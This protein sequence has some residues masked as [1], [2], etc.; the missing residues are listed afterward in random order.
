MQMAK[1]FLALGSFVFLSC[2]N[3]N[4]A[5]CKIPA[6]ARGFS[7]SPLGFPVT[8]ERTPEF[9]DDMEEFGDAAVRWNGSWRD[10]SIDGSDAGMIP[11]QAKLIQE[12]SYQYCYVATPVFEWRN[13][14][15]N[16]IQIP[17]NLVNDW[18]NVE[19]RKKFID[20]LREFVV[21]Y[22]PVYVFLGNENDLYYET[23]TADYAHWLIAYNTAY[24]AI[25]EANPDTLVGPV[26]SYEHI[27]GQGNLHGWSAPFWQAYDD[28]DPGK[29]DVV[30]ITLFPFFEYAKPES[31][32]SNYL[33]PLFDRI[34]TKPLVITATGWPAEN[35]DGFN[36]PW[37]PRLESQV[38][39]V[40]RL[41]IITAGENVPVMNWLYY[42]G[43]VD[44]GSDREFWKI[45]GS[46]SLLDSLGLPYL[47]YDDWLKL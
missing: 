36:P 15:Q 22:R 44:D 41:Q 17:S 32:P 24:D 39:Y 8:Y 20:M 14:N 46:V 47:V 42:N 43:R 45:Y 12:S 34:G 33:K 7:Y 35:L 27:S 18:T 25:K 23:N 21:Q 37:E 29:V 4:P 13:P 16:L 3:N 5:N 38:T 6:Q 2:S 9:F 1:V 19:A 30:G 28:H 11:S 26:F 40:N 31:I 10:D